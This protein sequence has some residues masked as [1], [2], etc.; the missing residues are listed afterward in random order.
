MEERGLELKVGAFV[1]IG[2]VLLFTIVFSIGKV[3]VFQ[4][5]YRI[6]I[7]FNFAGGIADAAPVRLAG[8]DIGEVDRIK[9]FYDD[10]I[11]KTRVE[12]LTWIKKRIKIE[13]DAIARIN[14]LGLLGEK[15]LE[16]VPGSHDA[17]FVEPNGTLIG[18]DPVM[19]DELAGDIKNLADSASV[20]MG[21]LERGEG[22]LGRFLTDDSIYVGLEEFVNDIKKHPWKLFRKK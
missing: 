10:Q 9:I 21:K 22:T 3:Y 14:T 20:V 1:F 18:E 8:V 2:I 6:R 5:G 7:L 12:V 19:I 11:L 16:I 17:G 13:K 15:Y 4:P